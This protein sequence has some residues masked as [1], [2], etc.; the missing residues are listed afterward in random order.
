MIKPG[1]IVIDVGINF[2]DGKLVGDVDFDEVSQIAAA[3]TPVPGGVGSVTTALLFR[4][5]TKSLERLES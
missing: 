4:H 2:V 3:I 1:S 5:Y